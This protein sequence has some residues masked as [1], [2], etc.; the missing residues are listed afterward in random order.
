MYLDKHTVVTHNHTNTQKH[1]QFTYRVNKNTKKHTQSLDAFIEKAMK[2]AHLPLDTPC[3]KL[4]SINDQQ[5]VQIYYN[6]FE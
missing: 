4:Y 6:L 2:E 3:N 1:T 5:I